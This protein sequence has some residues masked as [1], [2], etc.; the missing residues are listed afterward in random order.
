[1]SDFLG[2]QG[3][4]VIVSGCFSGMG[5]AT[6]RILLD[7]GA[8]VHGFDYKDCALPLASFTRLDL[9]DEAAID[10]A[11]AGL[12]GKF[13]ALFNCAGLPNIAPVL[14]IMKVN[15]LAAR[16]MTQAITPL[17]KEGSAVA[18]I[19]STAG[20]GWPMRLETHKALASTPDFASG[21]KWCEENIGEIWEGYAFGKEAL[22]VWT[23]MEACHLIK[24]GIRLNCTLPGP[25]Q[26]PMM[27]DF[28]KAAPKS[29]IDGITQPINRYATPEEQARPMIFLNSEAASYINGVPL[30]VDGGFTGGSATGQ[31]DMS[32]MSVFQEEA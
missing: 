28:E 12:S 17:L 18:S 3:K 6:A 15:F 7:L 22:I 1:M 30:L 20:A 5:E 27:P 21:L 23:M 31:I 25:T 29:V 9:R 14:D 4:R 11:V 8:E 10:S 16:K 19:A 26:T 24:K 2:Y 32:F 13:D